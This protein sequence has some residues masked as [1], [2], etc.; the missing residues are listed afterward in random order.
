ML[1]MLGQ[2]SEHADSPGSW[3]TMSISFFTHRVA[4]E[5]SLQLS[6]TRAPH[7]QCAVPTLPAPVSSARRAECC[8]GESDGSGE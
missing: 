5:R 6:R 3:T 4:V 8:L 1:G 7:S 2:I